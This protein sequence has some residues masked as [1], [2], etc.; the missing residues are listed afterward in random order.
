MFRLSNRDGLAL[1]VAMLTLAILAAAVAA[2]FMATSAEIFTNSAE[3]GVGRSYVIAQNGLEQFL[4]KRTQSGW[5]DHCVLTGAGAPPNAD[6]EW[7]RVATPMGYADVVSR[8]VHVPTSATDPAIYLITSLGTDTTTH[9]SRG[10]SSVNAQRMV[11]EYAKWNTMTMNVLAS[12]T[13]L[14]GIDKKGT[15]GVISGVDACAGMHDSVAGVTVPDT[16]W[17]QSGS[18]TPQGKPP[19][20]TTKTLAQVEAATKIDWAGILGGAISP[21][22]TIPGGSWPTAAQFA[23]TNFWPIIRIH[24]NGYS[25]PG[26]G[27]GMIIADSD[28]TIS[29]SNMW[30]GVV[31]VG[32]ALTSNGN[33]TTSGAV[34]SGLNVLIGGVPGKGVA[35]S[36]ANGTKSYVYNSCAVTK[37]TSSM[38][39]YQVIPNSWMDNI[40]VY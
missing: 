38:A 8:R 30:S 24:T 10:M 6:S 35:Q 34:V 13:S 27:Q 37:A 36:T 5:C 4:A 1:P 21:T 31:L 14:S 23:D 17:D 29:G 7:T 33:N 40:A 2:G 12:W 18:F 25:L 32:G 28:F 3:R 20:D 19:Y 26:P 11:G 15:S 39:G 22:I 16:T 9:L